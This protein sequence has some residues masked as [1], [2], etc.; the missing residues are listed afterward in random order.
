MTPKTTLEEDFVYQFAAPKEFGKGGK[1]ICFAARASGL[2]R[3]TN[4]GLTWQPAFASLNLQE[5]LPALA[6]TIPPN[7]EEDPSVF[8][9]WNGGI[10]HSSDSG[11]NWESAQLPSPPPVVSALVIS[12]NFVQ[13]GI[14]F[15]GTLEDGVLCSTNR[16]RHWVTWNFGLLDLHILSRVISPG[17]DTDE[18]IFAGTPNGIFRSTN[19]GRAWREVLLPGGF[20][21][22]LSLAISP[23]FTRDATLFA[24]TEKHGLLRTRDGGQTWKRVGKPVLTKPVNAILLDPGYPRRLGILVL[25]ESA[26]LASWDDGETWEPWREATLAGKDIA[27]IYAPKGFGPKKRVLVGLLVG[28]VQRI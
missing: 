27:A 7:P 24:G 26:L 19:G 13:D 6:V 8:V 9:G 11:Q 28:A 10:L 22:I 21:A 3:S 2:Y 1:D 15:S 12:P 17:F 23:D 25:H 4:S 20:K 14:L 16:G 5:T 18:T